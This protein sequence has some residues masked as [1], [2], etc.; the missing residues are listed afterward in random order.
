M[1]KSVAGGAYGRGDVGSCGLL[2]PRRF[3]WWKRAA[4]DGLC[5]L[6]GDEGKGS[7]AG[8]I[9]HVACAIK[10]VGGG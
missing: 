10:E 2:F 5:G 3:G 9:A 1:R 8:E 4:N 6:R 7:V